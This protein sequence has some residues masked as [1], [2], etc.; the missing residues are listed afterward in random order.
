[1]S[2]QPIGVKFNGYAGT[3]SSSTARLPTPVL[4]PQMVW[5][6][7]AIQLLCI[8]DH[9]PYGDLQRFRQHEN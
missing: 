2:T 3:S 8:C 9:K 6:Q 5:A 7:T 4:I 1:M